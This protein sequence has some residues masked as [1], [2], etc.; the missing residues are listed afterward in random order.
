[1]RNQGTT[2]KFLAW[3][4]YSET[5]TSTRIEGDRT[6]IERMKRELLDNAKSEENGLIGLVGT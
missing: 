6:D 1:M 4:T 2:D 5:L 3:A